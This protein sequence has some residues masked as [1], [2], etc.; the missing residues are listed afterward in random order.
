MTRLE[1]ASLARLKAMGISV[2]QRRQPAG[3]ETMQAQAGSAASA[4]RVRLA[5]GEG[6]WLLVQRQPW[7]GRADSILDDIRACLGPERCRFGQWAVGS[8]AGEDALE[9][10]ERGVRH[11]LSFGPAPAGDW[12]GLVEAP[13]LP[14][15]GEDWQAR[16]ALWRKL[17]PL[18]NER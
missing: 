3:T 9:L 4:A 2:W 7:G 18:L 1:S 10:A 16:R 11:I 6:D 5:S 14:E 15:L 8:P 12:T 13:T 17:K